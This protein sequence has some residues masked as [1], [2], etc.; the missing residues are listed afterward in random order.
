MEPLVNDTLQGATVPPAAE[1]WPTIGWHN[2]YS[3]AKSNR[4]QGT[5]DFW[6]SNRWR[7]STCNSGPTDEEAIDAGK[8]WGYTVTIDELDGYHFVDQS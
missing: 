3:I 4:K 7:N 8:R 6:V 1:P 2:F 5:E